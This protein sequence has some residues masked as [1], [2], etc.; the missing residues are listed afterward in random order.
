MSARAWLHLAAVIAPLLAAALWSVLM[1]SANGGIAWQPLLI[2]GAIGTICAQLAVLPRWRALERR[3]REGHGVWRTGLGMAFVTHV[4]FGFT[5][6]ALLFLGG[7]G[8]QNPGPG[9]GVSDLLVQVLFFFAASLFSL[10]FITLPATALLADRIA[11]LRRREL[12][13][14]GE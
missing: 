1:A 4:L 8:W 9:S 7:A 10:G 14:A 5:C 6:V 11:V 2:F 13:R 12:A 3:T